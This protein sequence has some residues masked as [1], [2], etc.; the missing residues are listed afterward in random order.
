VHLKPL[1]YKKLS[2]SELYQTYVSN[3]A[4]LSD[5]YET[6]PFSLDECSQKADSL[7]FDGGRKQVVALLKQFNKSFS[8]HKAVFKNI[9]RLENPQSLALVTGQQLGLYG[10]PIYTFFKTLTVIHLAR[11]LQKELHRPVIPVFWLAD[12]DHD[13]E[14]IRSVTIPSKNS[15]ETFSLSSRKENAQPVSD[16]PLPDQIEAVRSKIRSSLPETDFTGDLWDILDECFQPGASFRTAFGRFL[17]ELFGR[18]G[19][20]LAGSNDEPIKN[21]LKEALIQSVQKEDVIKRSLEQ[22][23]QKINRR[24]HQQATVSASHLFYL[25][26]EKGRVKI[27]RQDDKWVTETDK[28]WTGDD[29]IREI[30]AH[31]EAFSPDV[32]LRPVVQDKL[33]PVL[34]YVAGPGEIAYY[35]QMKTLY[36][37]FEQKMPIIFPRMSGTFIEPAIDRII[38][39]LPFEIDAYQQRIEDLESDFVERTGEVDIEAIFNTWKEEEHAAASKHIQTIAELDRT[40][41]GAAENAQSTYHNE[42]NKLKGKVYQAVKKRKN[43]QLNRI[44]RIHRNLFPERQLQ[45]R[46]F[47]GIYLMNKFGVDIWE[48]LL[49]EMANITLD[50][51]Q[52]IYL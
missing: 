13:Y 17:T 6:D 32:F 22:Q 50:E 52:L 45:E 43:I 26:P 39:E 31:P 10:G 27:Q 18:E 2:F 14:E 34:G 15:V 30:D 36:G 24:F 12:E 23:S 42:L 8:P 38:G 46:L 29:L 20:V 9:R 7:K 35:G 40:L 1:S 21:Y 49:E 11:K 19:L 48:R 4:R 33:L 3:F 25:H 41:K 44:R 51:H 28:N 47:C 16:I 37:A 5:F